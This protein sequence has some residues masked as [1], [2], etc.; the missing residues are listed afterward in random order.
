MENLIDIIVGLTKK[1]DMNLYEKIIDSAEKKFVKS[2][3]DKSVKRGK[4]KKIF[5]HRIITIELNKED[6]QES[7]IDFYSLNGIILDNCYDA[8]NKNLK[9]YRIIENNL[10]TGWE[11][12]Y[13]PNDKIPKG[14]PAIKTE[15]T[16]IDWVVVPNDNMQENRNK[17]KPTD[18]RDGK[19]R[20]INIKTDVLRVC[21]EKA[22]GIFE[23]IFEED[24]IGIDKIPDNPNWIQKL[25]QLIFSQKKFA[26][27]SYDLSEGKGVQIYEM[28][29]DTLEICGANDTRTNNEVKERFKID[30]EMSHVP[31]S[32][33]KYDRQKK[34]F[35]IVT[36]G[37]L[38]IDQ[39]EIKI[40]QGSTFHYKDL[41]TVS[42]LTFWSRWGKSI[43]I[44]FEALI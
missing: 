15:K 26:K 35:Q 44:K 25:F 29:T 23:I 30:I 41:E 20:A 31:Y 40:S 10:K 38:R 16:D 36:F 8:I 5:F 12:K 21:H 39:E 43:N 13:L 37:K 14:K 3:R 6:Y 24:R 34:L 42:K 33:I 22:Q 17:V 7:R 11:I 27:L 9:K 19:G 28:K 18:V 1:T 32:I 2:I 4:N